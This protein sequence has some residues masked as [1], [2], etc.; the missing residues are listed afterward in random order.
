MR[1]CRPNSTNARWR[2]R[3]GASGIRNSSAELRSGLSY[4]YSM[5]TFRERARR[6]TLQ[7]RPVIP[8]GS[9]RAAVGAIANACAVSPS[10]SWKPAIEA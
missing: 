2:R 8:V 4:S 5:T 7:H 6:H 3:A 10:S 9:L 1:H